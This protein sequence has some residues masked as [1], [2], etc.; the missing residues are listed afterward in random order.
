MVKIKKGCDQRKKEG[1]I[2]TRREF[3]EMVIDLVAD[4]KVIE[5]AQ[6]E[7]EK[8][9]ER[10]EKRAKNPSKKSVANEPIKANI[11]EY[12]AEKEPT[13]ASVIANALELK[14]QKVSALCRQMVEANIL[15]VTDVKVKNRGTQKAYALCA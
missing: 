11:A 3:L 10:N 9:N 2:M 4:E 8:M 13:T 6:R 1:I 5:Y 7:I 15:T 12:L 14:V